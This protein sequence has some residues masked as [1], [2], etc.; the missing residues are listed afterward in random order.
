MTP[1]ESQQGIYSQLMSSVRQ[2]K[3]HSR[4]EALHGTINIIT[5][6]R[7]IGRQSIVIGNIH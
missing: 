6:F 7:S 1:V 5:A 3:V 2:V 4:G